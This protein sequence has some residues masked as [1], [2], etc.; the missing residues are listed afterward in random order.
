MKPEEIL[1]SALS[2]DLATTAIVGTKIYVDDAPQDIDAPLLVYQRDSTE[3][4]NTI[5]GTKIGEFV[6]LAIL[7]K[8]TTRKAAEDLATTIDTPIR[9]ANFWKTE[10]VSGYEPD[11]DYHVVAIQYRYFDPE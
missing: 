10:Q 3:P 6:T 8:A 2:G 9:A 7:A 1:Y 11:V 4:R 5:H